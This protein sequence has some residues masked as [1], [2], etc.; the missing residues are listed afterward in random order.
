[1]TNPVVVPTEL[2]GEGVGYGSP[3][4]VTVRDP[5]TLALY[6]WKSPYPSYVTAAPRLWKLWR[7]DVIR[8]TQ[9]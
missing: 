9:R 7:D 3:R 8:N 5:T 6:G 1:M 2:S 4:L